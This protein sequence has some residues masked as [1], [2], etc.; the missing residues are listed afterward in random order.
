MFP[1]GGGRGS[2]LCPCNL[3]LR[4]EGGQTFYVTLHFSPPT[5]SN[6][7]GLASAVKSN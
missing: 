6:A 2:T 4:P 5:G 1:Q 3:R 7:R